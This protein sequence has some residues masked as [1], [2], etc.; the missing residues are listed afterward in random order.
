MNVPP[1]WTPPFKSHL[2]L[3]ERI[4][5]ATIRAYYVG[6]DQKVFRLKNLASVITDVIPEFA[7]GVYQG[8]GVPINELVPRLREA[9]KK[10]YTTEKY[11]KRGEFGE[12]ILHLLLRDFMRSI[13]L[14]SKIH[15]KDA[16][17]AIIHGFDGVHVVIDNGQKEL[18]LGESKLYDSGTKGIAS[19]LGDLE[20]HLKADYLRREFALV[21]TKLPQSNADIE[22]WREQLHE[23]QKLETILD[24]MCIPMVCT[25]TSTVFQDYDDNTAACYAAF[26]KECHEL[27]EVFAKGVTNQSL[28][29]DI[30]LLLL[31]VQSKPK[32]VDELH[33]RLK[34]MQ[35][36]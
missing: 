22:F 6:F 25:Y 10:V 12:L 24:R 17:N 18:W 11:Q 36:L 27:H 21:T 16:D 1:A 9:A 23:H 28:K 29:V 3:D 19:L 26:E 15:F 2:V 14:I 32:L 7:V 35:T 31:P 4:K 13:P 5:D 8:S 30:V 20:K 33:A 34:A